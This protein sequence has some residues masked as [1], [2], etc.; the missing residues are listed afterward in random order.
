MK[1]ICDRD[2]SG[3]APADSVNLAVNSRGDLELRSSSLLLGVRTLFT[4][5]LLRR[6]YDAPMALC[7]GL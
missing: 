3:I 4:A 6:K 1:E 2:L 7:A 5:L